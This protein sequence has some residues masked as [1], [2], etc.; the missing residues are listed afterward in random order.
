MKL[1]MLL[2]F[3][4]TRCSLYLLPNGSTPSTSRWMRPLEALPDRPRHHH[5]HASRSTCTR[6][7]LCLRYSAEARHRAAVDQGPVR[8]VGG[9]G[10]PRG[11]TVLVVTRP[12][13]PL[14]PSS[15]Q[16]SAVDVLMQHI[17]EHD[18]KEALCCFKLD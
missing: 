5:T 13:V 10:V 11:D 14:A 18:T 2:P 7:T 8:D 16:R 12:N 3:K 1:L 9:R 15:D 17:R 6:T 4:S